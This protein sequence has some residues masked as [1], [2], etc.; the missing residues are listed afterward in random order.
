MLS[1][2]KCRELIPDSDK[3]T[4]EE[5]TKMRDDMDALAN[6]FFDYWIAKRKKEKTKNISDVDDIKAG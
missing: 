6:I 4:D 2:E 1:V 5:I 3:Y